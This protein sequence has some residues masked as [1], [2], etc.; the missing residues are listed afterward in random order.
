MNIESVETKG[1]K[2]RYTDDLSFA[3]YVY[4]RG[5][6]VIKATEQRRGG[7]EYRFMFE[8]PDEK[9]EEIQVEFMNSEAAQ[10]DNSVRQLKQW[11]R[12]NGPPR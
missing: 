8:D 7:V 11:C 9:W 12:R 5:L 2:H 3:A 6:R 4:M 10:Y 1:P